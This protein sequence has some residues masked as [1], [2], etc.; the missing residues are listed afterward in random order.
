MDSAISVAGLGINWVIVLAFTCVILLVAC[1]IFVFLLREG[2][3]KQRLYDKFQGSVNE[4]IVVLSRRLEFLYGLPM[5][6]SD[7]LFARLSSGNIF[8]D[9]LR[10]KD[11]SRM[12]LYFDE[13]EKHQNMS[14]VFSVEIDPTNANSDQSR[15]Q[16]YEM[17]TVLD[18]VSVQEYRYICFIKN[19]TRENENRKE[20]ERIQVRLDNLLQNT[21]DFL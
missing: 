17:K 18:Y 6:T 1:C 10:S 5:Y 13:V 9:L 11:W 20:R 3:H 21:G 2:I 14:F 8:Q 19:F 12:K 4:F 7:P 15:V 16:W